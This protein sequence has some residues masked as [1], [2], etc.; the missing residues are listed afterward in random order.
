MAKFEDL[1][2]KIENLETEWDQHSGMEV[3]DFITRNLE[4][5][6]NNIIESGTYEDELLKLF[7]KD[8][9]SVDIPV[10]V[11]EP[12]YSFGIYIYALRVDGKVITRDLE[13][14]LIQYKKD[15]NFELGIAMYA[16]STIGSR[17]T[18]R[19]GSFPVKIK[20]GANSIPTTYS[21]VPI[22]YKYFTFDDSGT[23]SGLKLEEGEEDITKIVKWVKVN[24]IFSQSKTGE[25]IS[26]TIQ[27][28]KEVTNT[29]TL[30]DTFP[31][32]ITIQIISLTY[33]GD[34]VVNST[35]L[36][37]TLNGANSQ[38]YLLEVYN[39]DGK[40]SV[41]SGLTCSLKPGLNQLIARATN[42]SQ[43]SIKTDW[44]SIDIISTV[45]CNETVVAVNGVTEGIENN[46]IATLYDL[47]VYSPKQ[48]DVSLITYLSEF[49]PGLGDPNPEDSE[50][51]KTQVITSIDYNE[52]NIYQTSYYKYIE[53]R[54]SELLNRYLFIKTNEEFYSFHEIAES[55]SIEQ[56]FFKY[57]IM[58]LQPV[59]YEYCY[60]DQGILYS[61]DQINGYINN[62][63]IT[64]E[65]EEAI[66]KPANVSS[67]LE[68]S[69]GWKEDKGVIYFKAS[70]QDTPILTLND[71][72]LDNNFTF[73]V[74]FKTYNVSDESK[75][76][77]SLGKLQ[78]RPNQ[79]CWDVDTSDDKDLA[80]FNSRNSLFQEEVRTHVVITVQKDFT[81]KKGD[82]YYPDYLYSFQEK[83]DQAMSSTANS[84]N[85]FNLVRIFID[86]VIDREF[87]LTDEELNTLKQATLTINP[88]TTDVDFYLLRIYNQ[89]ALDF[90]QI[91]KNY[92][93]FLSNDIYKENDDPKTVFFNKND[94]V[95]QD[96]EISF[97]KTYGKYNTIVLVFPK[98]PVYPDRTN[99]F[100]SRA[101]GGVD[102]ADPT[103]NDDLAVTMFINYQD[104]NKNKNYGGRAINLRVRDQGT[105][106][107]RYFIW[108]V[109]TRFNKGSRYIP[110]E[111]GTPDT[112]QTEDVDGK[113]VPYKNLVEG[114][115]TFKP[116]K[117]WADVIKK[118]Y[119][120]PPYNGRLSSADI[121]SKK[122]V[123]KVNYASSMQSHKLGFCNMYDDFYQSQ[124]KIKGRKAVQQEPFVY[125]YWY[126]N[127]WYVDEIELQDLFD[128]DSGIS[129]YG[130]KLKFMGFQTWGSG[131]KD[132]D[133]SGYDDDATPGYLMLE[134]GEN[135]DT[136]VNFRCPWQEL[137]RN[138]INWTGISDPSNINSQTLLEEPQISYEESLEK[139]W[140]N[141]WIS[142]DESI[143]YDTTTA[144]VTGA[145]DVNYGLEEVEDEEG[146]LLGLRLNV[147][148]DEEPNKYMRNSVKTFREFYD[149]V[150][151]HDTNIV[152][153]K[154]SDT[155]NWTDTTKKY[156]C[157]SSICTASTTH[158][159]NDVYRYSGT[160]TTEN[161]QGETIS[162][163]KW[164]PAGVKFDMEQHKW[165]SYNLITDVGDSTINSIQK[166]LDY[167]KKDFLKIKWTSDG[168]GGPLDTVDAAIHQAT[169]RLASGT[170]NRAKNTYFTVRGPYF[171]EVP[172]NPE[173][174]D[175][176][177]EF[178][179]PSDY[180]SNV[181]KY[182]CVGF[183]QDD[184]D[185]VLATDNNGLQTK[186]YNIMEPSY[187]EED[188]KYWGDSGSNIFFRSFDIA[189]ES[190]I[191]EQLNKLISFVFNSSPDINDTSNRFYQYF[192]AVQDGFPAIAYNH[193]A[194]IY[195]ELGQ[196]VFNTGAIDNF[197]S[198]D[199]QP[200]Q[201][202]H[203][204]CINSEKQYMQKRLVFLGTQV[205]NGTVTNRETLPVN[206][207]S[208]T[209]GESYAPRLKMEFQTYQD[210]YPAFMQTG[211]SYIYT[212]PDSSLPI[213]R[214]YLTE[215]N[216]DY[217][218]V[219][220]R[221]L[222]VNN[223]ICLI[224]YYKK[225]KIAGLE[226][227]SLGSTSYKRA[228]KFEIDNEYSEEQGYPDSNFTDYFSPSFP[229]VEEFTLAN[230]ELQETFDASN[231]AKAKI[232]NFS[233]TTTKYVIFPNSGRLETV[234]LPQTIETFRIYNNPGLHPTIDQDGTREGIIFEGLDNLTTVEINCNNAGNFDISGFCEQLIEC[235]SLQSVTLK[236]A[237]IRITEEALQKLVMTN[238]CV[239]TGDIY[240]VDEPG[241]ETLKDISFDTKQRL[242][243]IFGDISSPSSALRIH[244]Q[245][246]QITDFT[247]AT[248][249]AVYYQA[250]ESGTIV[251]QNLFDI[252]VPVGNDVEIKQGANPF[253]P[254]INGYLDITYSMSGVSSD[255]ATI[256][257]TG[258]ITLKKE[259]SSTATVTISMKV[260]NNP[261]AIKKTVTVKFTWQAPELGD[262]AYADGTFTSSYDA[263]KTLVGLVYAKNVKTETTGTVFIIGKEFTDSDK[264]YYLGYSADGNEGS[265]ESIL[266]QLYQVQAYLNNVSIQNYEVV[267]NVATPQLINNI[268]VTTYTTS[269]NDSFSGDTDTQAYINHVNTKLLPTLYTNNAV[270][271]QYIQRT[272]ESGGSWTYYIDN[273]RDLNNLCGAIQTIWTNASSTDIMSCLLYPYFYS[274][275]VYEPSVKETET[276]NSQYKKGNWYA[277]SVAEFSRIIYYRGYSVSGNNFNTGDPVRQPIS[278]SVSKGS[279]TLT[280]PIFSMAYSRAGNNFPAVWNSVVGSGDNAG[281]NN[282]TTSINSSAANNYS[283]Q[284][285]SEYD[286]STS[287]YTYKNE[288]IT[289]SYTDPS[290]WNTTQYRNAWRLTKH[291]G[292]PFTKFDY[293]KDD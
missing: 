197:T 112:S 152:I 40:I 179:P 125:F 110:R 134:G 201:Q 123:G 41:D 19:V 281:V 58:P 2:N 242:V 98:D 136:A 5:L 53:N 39:Q 279:T 218:A 284:R 229:V 243:N 220:N 103:P 68:A 44:F 265:S 91:Q 69:D 254:S 42:K 114:T 130:G 11:T 87:I 154:E 149:F 18:D 120:M 13:E 246:S 178:V 20:Y 26:A 162:S 137:Q 255:V 169:I 237:N 287:G 213:C 122:N 247:C 101:W 124:I 96:G 102:N 276:L 170:D 52:E 105:S 67:T 244:F 21:V 273:I 177:T 189:Y 260:A 219:I 165:T 64:Q 221:D 187:R 271:R 216:K 166:A 232:L 82:T 204:S 17:V 25:K 183:L 150:Y 55:D 140:E 288:W 38:N 36:T 94:I 275:H 12:E 153:T 46:K 139:P 119:I 126:T 8:G 37:Y 31:T 3:E 22:P 66:G 262:F 193:T 185:T 207:G 14:Q 234:I 34:I 49:D 263:T 278:T 180:D 225:L 7:K 144:D 182:H 77:L 256:D 208:G 73:E 175:G 142:G 78:I 164:V 72:N 269:V 47:T 184:M 211:T 106:A 111:D 95:G 188:K 30:T 54:N 4:N 274:M 209:G 173:E 290:Y 236:N 231:F 143:I 45:N 151:T 6:D 133:T 108:N 56:S 270:C 51:L 205:L 286:S 158:K 89:K 250:G 117:E 222:A 171:D 80:T 239:L 272:Q 121:K 238:T 190:E 116:E 60:E 129:P 127:L 141:L 115:Y 99:Y 194:K 227:N 63:F 215:A 210:M 277:P 32:P 217:T 61:F 85:K 118:G 160:L 138:P 74:G 88:T 202:S 293:S 206:Q 282:I 132:D 230:M 240:I 10:T 157:T 248:E 176:D 147:G 224:S 196:L 109:D 259:S 23:V 48:E 84:N 9:T 258:A 161:E 28:D 280:T 24:D 174:P 104:E 212:N 253:N 107:S 283:Y 27:N 93:S 59:I 57:K 289:G 70:A 86:D 35:Q 113:F 29:N 291:Q 79:V 76:F 200:I 241:S 191:N 128:A 146:N 228:V 100:P 226:S 195:Y 167:L 71:L 168:L 90:D 249:V 245:S 267:S 15:K 50:Q 148:T 92:I 145:W 97:T 1:P 214:R 251:R 199:Q 186:P 292:I 33:S 285:T 81:I 83:F 261:S 156:C 223:S 266:Q 203:G 198:N 192:F 159:A 264:S 235:N 257:Q 181:R 16:I 172:V 268:N 62:V 75:P 65:Y 131:K 43:S 155:T 252:T 135:G 163:G 233:G